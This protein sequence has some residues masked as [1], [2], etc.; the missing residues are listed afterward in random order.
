M[1]GQWRR[2]R[3]GLGGHRP[4]HL[5]ARPSQSELVC[6]H[7]WSAVVRPVGRT[8]K[9][10]K[11]TEAAYGR[12]MNMK[13]SGNSSGGHS[14]SQHANCML[15]QTWDLFG[16]VFCDKTAH[17]SG[18]LLPPTQGAPIMFMLFNQHINMPHLSNGWIILA[19]EKC[20]LTGM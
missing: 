10:S 6:P 9:F 11:M 19:K 13:L 8:A 20:L 2:H 7:K 4:T 14:W 5:G 16:I 12:E 1:T 17:F 15:P 3:C 18:L